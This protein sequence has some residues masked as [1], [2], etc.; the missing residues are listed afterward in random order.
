MTEVIDR[1][2]EDQALKAK[3]A[4]MWASGDYPAVATELIPD[5]GPALVTAAGISAGDKVL[6]VAAGTG[7]AALPAAELGANVVA[8]DL[9]PELL[10][11]GRGYA[12]ARGVEIEWRV[13]DAEALPFADN[14][15]DVT[16]SSVGVMFAPHHQETA[17]ELLRVTRP[18]GTISVLNWTPQGFIGQ[19]F[20]TMKPFAPPPPKGAQS[21]PLWGTEEHVSALLGDE[22]SDVVVRREKLQVNHFETPEG[23]RDY[24]KACYGPTISVYKFIADQ[25]ERV[26]EL[27]RAMVDVAARFTTGT[28]MEWEYLIFTARKND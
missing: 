4:A 7:N 27:D 26:A 2:Q 20:A 6:D 19:V 10:E 16:I 8:T 24:F 28:T 11:T 23:F 3:H 12:E 5:L 17:D 1:V 22:I 14:E 13:A 18:G 25:P 9:T 21:P 15:F